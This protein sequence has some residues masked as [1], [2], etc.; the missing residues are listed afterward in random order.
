MFFLQV[1][2]EWVGCLGVWECFN[3]VFDVFYYVVVVDEEGVMLMQVFWD[4]IQN[5]FFIVVGFIVCLFGEE[6]YW[7]VFIQQVQ[8]VFW[9][10]GGVWI[11]ID[12]V[13][14][15]VVVEVCYQ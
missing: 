12:V 10:V 3:K 7:V 11:E 14:Q 5:M 15:Q 1:W 9:V 4:N 6:G 2:E 8:F 13:F